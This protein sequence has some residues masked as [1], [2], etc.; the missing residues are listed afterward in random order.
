MKQK[1]NEQKM[2]KK[3]DTAD[4]RIDNG[5]SLA[6]AL[7]SR[8]SVLLALGNGDSSLADMQYAI[9]NGLHQEKQQS[10]YYCRLAR[11]N[12]RKYNS[13][14]IILAHINLN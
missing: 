1:F 5:L 10:E 11:A 2:K 14:H 13:L 8:S 4:P 12:A 3:S 7:W 9:E 6:R